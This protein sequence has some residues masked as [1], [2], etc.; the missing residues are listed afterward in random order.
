MS[1]FSSLLWFFSQGKRSK[2]KQSNNV[3]IVTGP[4]SDMDGVYSVCP[5]ASVTPPQYLQNHSFVPTVPCGRDMAAN[6]FI[7]T[8]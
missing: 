8:V 7:P 4:P 2:K 1:W 6:G 5:E 3:A